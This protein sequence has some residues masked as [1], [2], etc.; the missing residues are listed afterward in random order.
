MMAK[1]KLKGLVNGEK[2]AFDRR[3]EILERCYSL[4]T[5]FLQSGLAERTFF[6]TADLLK[7]IRKEL[8]VLPKTEK[9]H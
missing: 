2:V 6:K 8:P 7:D 5:E 4:L 1:R 9:I 3:T